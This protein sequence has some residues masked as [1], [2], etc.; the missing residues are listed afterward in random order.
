AA[1]R[2]L[3]DDANEIP[4]VVITPLGI[5][6]SVV[7]AAVAGVQQQLVRQGRRPGDLIDTHRDY[8]LDTDGLGRDTQRVGDALR[9]AVALA[10]DA[11]VVPEDADLVAR[12]R[13]PRDAA[14]HVFPGSVRIRRPV[15][16]RS[17]QPLRGVAGI[18]V[19]K[20][21]RNRSRAALRARV[22]KV[23]NAIL[24][25]WTAERAIDV[26]HLRERRWRCEAGIL[27]LLREVVGLQILAGRAEVDRSLNR[28]ATCFRYD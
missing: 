14:A 2:A 26:V 5:A 12:G 21:V 13:L 23:P 28:V 20:S 16:I 11:L 7:R 25:D 8:A 22:D 1:A 17:V 6:S 24:L 27:E 19:V 4:R 9:H 15:Q 18:Q 3:L 10:A